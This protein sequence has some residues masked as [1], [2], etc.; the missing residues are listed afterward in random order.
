MAAPSASSTREENESDV[1]EA[2]LTEGITIATDAAN[3]FIR[4]MRVFKT[5]TQFSAA[6]TIRFI[7]AH[8]LLTNIYEVTPGLGWIT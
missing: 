2:E 7:A 4:W 6:G 1:V 5:W 3:D 8:G